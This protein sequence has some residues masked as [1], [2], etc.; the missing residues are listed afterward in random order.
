M[1]QK[2]II[3]IVFE[4]LEKTR[5]KLFATLQNSSD[6]IFEKRF[7][8]KWNAPEIV[9]HLYRFEDEVTGYFMNFII[10]S[11][12]KAQPEFSG[13]RLSQAWLDSMNNDNEKYQVPELFIPER[14]LKEEYAEKLKKSR[15][16]LHGAVYSKMSYD[17]SKIIVPHPNGV[18]LN[19]VQWLELLSVH[20]KRHI[21]QLEHL[22]V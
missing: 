18:K 4:D 14:V 7:D 10:S 21:R 19:L 3:D 11:S 20:E 13:K 22:A 6:K 16:K 9:G 5:N 2:E 8:H 17:F 12:P 15:E 1:N